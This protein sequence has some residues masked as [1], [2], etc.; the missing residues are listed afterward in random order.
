MNRAHQGDYFLIMYRLFDLILKKIKEK[1]VMLD[2]NLIKTR[3][4]EAKGIMD[5]IDPDDTPFIGAAL[6]ANADIWSDDQ[7]YQKQGRIKV[8]KTADLVSLL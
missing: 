4:D 6:A 3:W 1:L 8:W 5:K 7:H 2:D